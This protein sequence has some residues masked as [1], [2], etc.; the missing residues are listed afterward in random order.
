MAAIPE[1]EFEQRV[2]DVEHYIIK[3]VTQ[4]DVV[5]YCRQK[6]GV[7]DRTARGYIYAARD[8]I[9]EAYE[10]DKEYE[11]AKAKARYERF[12]SLAEDRNE[13]NVAVTSQT[14][15]VKLLGLAEPEKAEVKHD[16][17]DEFVGVFR[18]I[19]KATDKPA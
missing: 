3:G 15:L 10:K 12:M 1:A 18:G 4:S 8:Q 16:L 19:V 2:R 17:T 7:C 5:A 11:I 13:L 14:Q 9:K 6:Y